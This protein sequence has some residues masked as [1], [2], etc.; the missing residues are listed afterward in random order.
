MWARQ[1]PL[2]AAAKEAE[3]R[4][5]STSLPPRL[6]IGVPFGRVPRQWCGASQTYGEFVVLGTE[7]R[8][9]EAGGL[10]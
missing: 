2:A 7:E 3:R 9:L 10:S 6:D 1:A 4:A 5:R 8:E